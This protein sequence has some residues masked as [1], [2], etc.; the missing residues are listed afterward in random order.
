MY[1]LVRT[2]LFCVFFAIGFGSMS[3]SFLAKEFDVYYNNK[4]YKEYVDYQIR[5]LENKRVVY[6]DKLSLLYGDPDIKQRLGRV[7]FG[8]EQQ[9]E[10]TVFPQPGQELKDESIS[11]VNEI[12]GSN[13][14]LTP[15]PKWVTSINNKQNQ[16]VLL[17]GGIALVVLSMFFFLDPPKKPQIDNTDLNEPDEQDND[18]D[19]KL[20]DEDEKIITA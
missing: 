15:K 18:E 4:R 14:E 2:L 13:F 19:C 17:Y 9:K 5:I 3:I 11:A 20:E 16:N 7:V 12:I 1:S 8:V 10:D 6:N